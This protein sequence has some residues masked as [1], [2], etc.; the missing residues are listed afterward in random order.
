MVK[1]KD[2]DTISLDDVK[3]YCEQVGRS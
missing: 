1:T 3:E 2:L